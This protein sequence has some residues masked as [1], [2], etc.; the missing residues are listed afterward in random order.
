[1]WLRCGDAH[2]SFE[3]CEVVFGARRALQLGE[4]RSEGVARV[5]LTELGLR[6]GLGL[7]LVNFLFHAIERLKGALIAKAVHRFVDC[8]LRFCALLASDEHILL[9][10]GFFDFVVEKAKR[11][12]QLVDA[13]ALLLP[14]IF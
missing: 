3:G 9:A 10:L 12:L 6:L 5:L 11:L 2:L 1:L 14:L 7:D 8:L 13:F 4:L